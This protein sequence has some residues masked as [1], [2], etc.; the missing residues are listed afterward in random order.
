MKKALRKDFFREIQ[1]NK[2]RFLSLTF[3]VAL[4]VAFF[5]GIRSTEQDMNLSADVGYDE[6]HFMD[7]RV[8]GTLGVT[9]D[10][11]EAIEQIDGVDEVEGIFS[12]EA[13]AASEETEYVLTAMTM[14]TRISIPQL[15]E[16]RL[17]ADE[18]ECLLD[19]HVADDYA[20]VDTI[21]LYLDVDETL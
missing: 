13:F 17:P 16:G 7:I 12:I 10:D 2:S 14:T 6:A 8:L 15:V 11:I 21:S 3:I 1:R 4:G 18:T 9:D 5:C 19:T 20:I